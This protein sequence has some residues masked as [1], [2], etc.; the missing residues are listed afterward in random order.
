MSNAAQRGRGDASE[1]ASTASMASTQNGGRR[2]SSAQTMDQVTTLDNNFKRSTK[3][4]PQVT[5]KATV[6]L[7]MCTLW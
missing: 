2:R 1:T 3:K 6:K 4:L 5:F 7:V